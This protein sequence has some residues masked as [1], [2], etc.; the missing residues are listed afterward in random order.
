M[1]AGGVKQLDFAGHEHL[2]INT[3]SLAYPSRRCVGFEIIWREV[4]HA[5]TGTLTVIVMSVENSCYD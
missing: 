1:D 2:D 4:G 3:Q 5:S